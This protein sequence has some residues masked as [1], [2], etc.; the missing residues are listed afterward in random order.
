MQI[1]GEDITMWDTFLNIDG[2]FLELLKTA[3]TMLTWKFS[4]TGKPTIIPEYE[5]PVN[6]VK[7]IRCGILTT[8]KQVDETTLSANPMMVPSKNTQKPQ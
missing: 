3:Y 6:T 4:V 2:G 8:I 1:T 7:V 5:L